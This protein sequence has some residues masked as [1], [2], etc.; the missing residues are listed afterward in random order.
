MQPRGLSSIPLPYEV[1]EGCRSN[2]PAYYNRPSL[3]PSF[4]TN[5]RQED[6]ILIGLIILLLIEGSECDYLLVGVLAIIFLSGIDGNFLG[7]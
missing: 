1:D 7:L 4:F 5:L 6:I 2:A 3:L